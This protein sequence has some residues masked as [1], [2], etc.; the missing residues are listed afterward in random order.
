MTVSDGGLP[1][2]VV[3]AGVMPV[4]QAA[5]LVAQRVEPRHRRQDSGSLA[6]SV[7]HGRYSFGYCLPRC[8]R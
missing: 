2:A 1:G 4:E 8:S 7:A 5:K 3:V 6:G